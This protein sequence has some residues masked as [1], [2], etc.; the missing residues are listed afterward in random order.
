MSRVIRFLFMAWIPM[1]GQIVVPLDE[2]ESKGILELLIVD[3]F[4]HAVNSPSIRVEQLLE[5]SSAKVTQVGTKIALEYGEYRILV[6][7]AG[8]DP[9]EKRVT[10]NRPYQ[11]AVI[12]LFTGIHEKPENNAVRGQLIDSDLR[13]ECLWIRLLSPYAPLSYEAKA[14]GSGYFLFENVRPGQ[15]LM[16][17][18]GDSGICRMRSVSILYRPNQVIPN[19]ESLE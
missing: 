14:A 9:A 18:L 11:A 2:S 19:Q 1:S 4:G 16:L 10:V 17:T 6:E 3:A 15:Y 8:F 12:C 5:N 13:E 7:K